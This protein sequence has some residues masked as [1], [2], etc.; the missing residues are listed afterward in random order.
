MPSVLI[1]GI[2]YVPRA[3][4]PELTDARLKAALEEL[5]SI[6][7]FRQS[8]KAIPQAW[9]VLRALAPEL[10]ELSAR[11]PLAAFERIHGAEE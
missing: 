5:V 6:Q 7:Y 10:A 11:D 1:D 3:E 8:H 4:V 9:N 2:E